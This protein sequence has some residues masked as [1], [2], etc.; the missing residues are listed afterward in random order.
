MIKCLVTGCPSRRCKALLRPGSRTTGGGGRQ[1]HKRFF[2]LP[3]D[4]ARVKV[5]LAAL[6]ETDKRLD[7]SSFSSSSSPLERKHCWLCEDHFLPKHITA[8]GG[9]RDDAIPIMPPYLDEVLQGSVSPWAQEEEEEEEEGQ[10]E[11]EEEEE[12]Q[13]EEEEEEEEQHQWEEEEE[14]DGGDGEGEAAQQQPV[15]AAK[16]L[17]ATIDGKLAPS[18]KDVRPDVQPDMSLSRLTRALLQEMV[19]APDGVLDLRQVVTSLHTRRRRVYDI[20]NVLSSLSLIKKDGKSPVSSFLRGRQKELSN[21]K[22]VEDSLDEVFRDQT[23]MAVVAPEDTTLEVP[24]PKENPPIH[25]VL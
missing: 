2:S 19:N 23:I 8:A 11:E 21:L 13:E 14:D 22:T 1:V 24:T 5:W 4:P 15:S 3:N 25:R 9:I 10:E 17:K 6:R 16:R 18:A 20:T 7:D 12:E